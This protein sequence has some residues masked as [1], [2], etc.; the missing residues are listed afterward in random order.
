[1]KLV[2]RIDGEHA[3]ADTD[4]LYGRLLTAPLPRR[5]SWVGDTG[6]PRPGEAGRPYVITFVVDDEFPTA[7]LVTA[8]GDW[9]VSTGHRPQVTIRNGRGAE[10]TIDG[11]GEDSVDRVVGSLRDGTGGAELA[12]AP[13]GTAEPTVPADSARS[14][15]MNHAAIRVAP[16]PLAPVTEAEIEAAEAG[17]GLRFPAGYREFV[18]RFGQGLLG[19]FLRVYPPALILNEY[20]DVQQRWAEYWFWGAGHEVL[21]KDKA[22]S[23]VIIA[24]TTGG[25]ELVFHPTEPD[26]LYVLPR[27]APAVHAVGAN[28]DEA[29]AWILTP[30]NLS[31]GEID[32][33][34]FEPFQQ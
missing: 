1:M 10:V 20:R 26:R 14:H 2:V 19:G 31:D 17:L 18:T 27:N 12:A 32:P 29:M 5:S 4:V 16:G 25:D 33:T 28:L 24:D 8:V 9:Y 15:P 6:R 13:Q 34:T 21:A 7:D 23:C 22:L 11:T 3:W 30:G